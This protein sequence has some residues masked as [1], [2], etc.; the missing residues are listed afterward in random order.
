MENKPSPDANQDTKKVESYVLEGEE[1]ISVARKI[2]ALSIEELKGKFSASQLREMV[3]NFPSSFG[4]EVVPQEV[5]DAE[6]HI[7]STY[8]PSET[9]Q[10]KHKG[11]NVSAIDS[12]NP[13]EL[14]VLREEWKSKMDS[15]QQVSFLEG[16]VKKLAKEYGLNQEISIVLYDEV[17]SGE[18]A[19]WMPT[20]EPDKIGV[21]ILYKSVLKNVDLPT[22][23][24]L[25]SHEISH[26]FQE[27]LTKT[28]VEKMPEDLADDK[29]WF[30]V[31][32]D[33]FRHRSNY[34]E[35]YKASQLRYKALPPEKDAWAMQS[36]A[37]EELN[38]VSEQY[39]NQVL[40]SEGLG[41]Y[42]DIKKETTVSRW[43]TRNLKEET[44]PEDLI[45]EA[46]KLT[47]VPEIAAKIVETVS[48]K[49][50]EAIVEAVRDIDERRKKADLL[51]GLAI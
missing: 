13:K 5:L 35:A 41:S 44:T 2:N 50:K 27:F 46:E 16:Y 37:Y 18:S 24:S 21:L 12:Y 47:H 7:Y 49:D 15:D 51:L 14:F 20:Y 10:K 39:A 30:K 23:M 34:T 17:F 32:A 25:V 43:I 48:G 11:A 40:M 38:R 42:S 22:A 1:A 6:A 3:E 26:G 33:R 4:D 28:V 9:L 19:M 29:E 31:T 36:A 45:K 8:E